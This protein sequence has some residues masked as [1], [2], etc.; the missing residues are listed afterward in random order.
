M[1]LDAAIFYYLYSVLPFFLHITIAEAMFVFGLKRRRLFW[2]RLPAGFVMCGG[3]LFIFS[4]IMAA[5]PHFLF[6]AFMYMLMF[7]LTL[8]V[9]YFC[10]DE[11]FR[12]LLFCGLAAYTAQNM[13]YRLYCIAET[14]GLVWLLAR[15]TNWSVAANSINH[16]L[17]YAVYVT[18]YFTIARRIKKYKLARLH[19]R[20]VLL[21][22]AITL[23]VTALLCA[24]TNNYYWQ[25]IPLLIINFLF[26]VLA[27][28]FILCLQS[29]MLVKLG[30]QHD[31]EIVQKLWHD[32]IARYELSKENI[33]IINVKCHDLKHRLKELRLSGGGVSD[34]EIAEMEDAIS[35]Y[36]ANINTGCEPLDVILT[37]KSLHCRKSGIKLSCMADGEQLG[38]MRVGE[39]Y[40]LFGNMLSN[41]IEAVQ[42]VDD[43]SKRVISFTV[44]RMGGMLVICTENYY[45]GKIIF[46]NGLPQTSKG[47]MV[48]HG[49]GTKSMK[50]LVNKYGGEFGI[51]ADGEIYRLK[52]I[53]PLPADT[54]SAKMKIAS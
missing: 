21:I 26:S 11:S 3:A 27:C 12:T 40:T 34:E 52:I 51:S 24:W 43:E 16:L 9:L 30:M 36:D 48:N 15:R 49:Y 18:V 38:F 20:N 32:D 17:M 10:F 2:V 14:S 45:N 25:H 31:M 47:D 37:E 1:K 23:S 54:G 41:A 44:R 7:A 6:G 39:L 22:S 53:L 42:K 19:N 13:A 4:V 5:V 29:G 28:V 50:M 33:D 35:I 8:A 46:K